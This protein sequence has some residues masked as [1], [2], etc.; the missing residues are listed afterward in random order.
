MNLTPTQKA[1]GLDRIASHREGFTKLGEGY[2]F[3]IISRPENA[4]ELTK[5]QRRE[6][7]VWGITEWDESKLGTQPTNEE[8]EIAAQ[9]DSVPQKITPRQ[10]RLALVD[11]GISI[12]QVES[13][14]N[15]IEDETQKEKALI[16][17]EYALTFNRKHPLI[18]QMG[19]SLGISE[20][21]IDNL[22][23][24]GSSIN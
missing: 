16:E 22:F 7:T 5:E 15:S 21:D 8:I 23:I 18:N 19:M 1:K 3:G 24:S 4:K 2:S 9:K 10:L 13:A 12:S 20:T 11:S 17:W 14:L 6:Q